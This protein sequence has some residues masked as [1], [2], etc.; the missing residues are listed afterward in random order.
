MRGLGVSIT[1]LV[2]GC[3]FSGPLPATGDGPGGDAAIDAAID[4]IDARPID[5]PPGSARKKRITIDPAQVS[6]DHTAFP[7]WILLA[8]DNDLMARATMTGSDIY[9]TK[10]DGTP[11]EHQIQR[12]TKGSGRLE[13]WVR[14]DLS[15]TAETLLDLRYGD[16]GPAHAPNPPL[17]FGS[18][19]AAVWHLDDSL[20]NSTIADARNMRNGTASGGLNAN[21]KV[22]AQLGDGIR[23][24]GNNNQIQ[25]ANP[26]S[27]NGPHTIS[28][29]INQNTT[30]NCDSV[31]T[32]GNSNTSQSRFLHSRYQASGAGVGVYNNDWINPPGMDLANDGWVLVHW[33]LDGIVSRLYRDGV[34]LG[35]THQHQAGINTQGAA[36]YLGYAPA[37]WGD[38]GLNGSLDEVRLAT[39][40][41]NAGWIA[42]EYAN[43][44]PQQTFYSVGPEEVVP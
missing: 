9:F 37:M 19:Y 30:N 25:F 39:V 23:F 7:V 21:D 10:P 35:D 3:K 13:A 4:A 6:G 26:Y 42:T 40:A 8:N 41:R 44:K 24:N 31:V 27:G 29:W 43:Q 20:A 2:A 38:C 14:V 12:W 22:T 11:L 16:P 1:V 33:V 28:A 34:E 5:G 18:S 17:V 32:V 15:D 36:G